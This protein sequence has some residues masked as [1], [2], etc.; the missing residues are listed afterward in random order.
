LS[1]NPGLAR[2]C[3]AEVLGTFLFVFVGAGSAVASQY[4][5]I[6]D[7]GSALLVAAFANGLGLAIGISVTMGVSGGALNPA[8]TIGLLL[9]RKMSARDVLPYIVAEFIG[10]TLAGVLLMASS[11]SSAGAAAH[12]G[13]PALSSAISVVQ[14]TLF[15]LVMTFLLVLAVYGTIVDPRAPKIAGFGVGLVVVADVL[16]GGPFT[17]AAM[18]PA[19]AMGPMIASLSFPSYWYIYWIGPIIGAAIAGLVYSRIIENRQMD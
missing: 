1:D 6:T 17:G 8:V 16:V 14:G 15:E 18:N 7:P 11:P 12:W 3:V 5:G 13:A 2:K 19:R 9:G 10:A 4:L